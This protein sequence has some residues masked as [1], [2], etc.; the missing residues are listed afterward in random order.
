MQFDEDRPEGINIVSHYD[1]ASFTIAHQQYDSAIIVG[2]DH[3]QR[4]DLSLFADTNALQTALA[5]VEDD[6]DGSVLIIGTGKQQQFPDNDRLRAL[7][8]SNKG[9]SRVVEIMDTGAACRTYNLLA[10]DQ[11]SVIAVML[12]AGEILS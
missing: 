7:M 9:C 8:T 2:L 1:E 3:I 11:R 4:I 5:A 10:G 12:L 6:I